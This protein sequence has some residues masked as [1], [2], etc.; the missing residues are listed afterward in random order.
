MCVLKHYALIETFKTKGFCIYI[1]L[2]LVFFFWF[3]LS[4]NFGGQSVLFHVRFYSRSPD[5][6]P[7]SRLWYNYRYVE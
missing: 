2:F 6:Y 7:F 5:E 3:F 1:F 4:V